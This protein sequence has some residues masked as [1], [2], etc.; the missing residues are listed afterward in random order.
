MKTFQT[1]ALS[2][3]LA[4]A[5][6]VVFASDPIP[7]AE[8]G[9]SNYGNVDGWNIFSDAERE[10]CFIERADENGNVVQ[11]GLT[12]NHKHSYIGVFTQA[13]IDVK[14]KQKIEIDINGF[15]FEGKAHGMKSKELRGEYRGGYFVVKDDNM[16]NAIMQEGTLTA[17]PKKSDMIFM[18]NLAGANAAIDEARKCNAAMS[19]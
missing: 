14:N 19:N 12:K 15:V 2:S 7:G 9:F 8:D 17:F 3:F 13:P 5:G 10:A 11:M 16:V 4:C 1:L 6:S 18:V